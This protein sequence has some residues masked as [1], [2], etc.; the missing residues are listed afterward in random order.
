MTGHGSFMSNP[1]GQIH[2]EHVTLAHNFGFVPDDVLMFLQTPHEALSP[3]RRYTFQSCLFY[4]LEG[5]DKGRHLHFTAGE[6]GQDKV[7]FDDQNGGNRVVRCHREGPNALYNE[8]N[9]R[10]G[11]PARDSKGRVRAGGVWPDGDPQQALSGGLRVDNALKLIQRDGFA[12]VA[13]A[14]SPCGWTGGYW[15]SAT[16]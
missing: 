13:L 1:A 3:A 16:N 14:D 15:S 8:A 6:E 7:F 11:F 2:C 5:H 9:L 10:E 12:L 4:E